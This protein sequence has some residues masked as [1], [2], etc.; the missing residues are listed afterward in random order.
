MTTDEYAMDS[1]CRLSTTSPM[2]PPEALIY[3][4]AGMAHYLWAVEVDGAARHE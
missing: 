3:S 4:I 2:H 1:V